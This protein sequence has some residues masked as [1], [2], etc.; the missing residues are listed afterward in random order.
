M[1]LRVRVAAED[2]MLAIEEPVQISANN[3]LAGSITDIRTTERHADVRLLCGQTPFVARITRAS[4]ERLSLAA[5]MR[6]FAIVK[7]VTVAPQID[8]LGR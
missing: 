6:V 2:V 1:R 5:G 7:S 8:P 4:R 3:I